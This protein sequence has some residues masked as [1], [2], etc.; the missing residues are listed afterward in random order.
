MSKDDKIK[1]SKYL[2][3]VLLPFL[4]QFDHE[5]E[6]EREIEAKIQGITSTLF[7]VNDYSC[8]DTHGTASW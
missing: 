3:K 6:M 2:V 1:H 4:E 8:F 7:A 5:Q